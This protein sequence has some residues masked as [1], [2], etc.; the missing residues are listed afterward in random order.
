MQIRCHAQ[1][2]RAVLLQTAFWRCQAPGLRKPP[3]Y[4][5]RGALAAF[6]HRTRGTPAAFQL[7][8]RPQFTVRPFGRL[9]YI[10]IG[11]RGRRAGSP[12]LQRAA[13]GTGAGAASRTSHSDNIQQ[14]CTPQ[15]I[16]ALAKQ[17]EKER[18]V[19]TSRKRPQATRTGSGTSKLARISP[20]S[21]HRWLL[22]APHQT[23]RHAPMAAALDALLTPPLTSRLAVPDD[24]PRLLSVLNGNGIEM[25]RDVSS[26]WKS[27]GAAHFTQGCSVE[28]LAPMSKHEQKCA[29]HWLQT[30][31]MTFP[32]CEFC[33]KGTSARTLQSRESMYALRVVSCTGNLFMHIGAALTVCT[34]TA[35]SFMCHSLSC[36]AGDLEPRHAS[37][38]GVRLQSWT[39]HEPLALVLCRSPG[40][41]AC[42][43]QWCAPPELSLSCATRSHAVQVT[44]SPGMRA[45]V[46]TWSPGMRASMVCTSRAEP[47]MCHSLVF[48]R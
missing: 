17:T 8:K 30:T 23:P 45:A 2:S 14:F 25:A 7:P 42:A 28:Q 47:L 6:Q 11:Q 3:H 35:G 32:L 12:Q 44:W 46:V 43:L 29:P 15:P 27:I 33:T 26:C 22:P 21:V 13:G 9:G 39:S 10:T 38:N 41:P 19:C 37:C 20:K 31:P 24:L 34:F 18:K 4:H 40:A 5:T 36:C 1:P 48:C 16:P